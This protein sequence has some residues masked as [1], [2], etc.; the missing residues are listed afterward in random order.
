MQPPDWRTRLHADPRVMR[1]KPVIRGTR[2][3][4]E[5]VVRQLAL[6]VSEAELV[7][8][9]V[10]DPQDVRACLAYA[11]EAVADEQVV[12]APTH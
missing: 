4:V 9:Y 10:I 12:A 1:G 7:R 5:L 2:L 8:E 6:G 3:T 11:A